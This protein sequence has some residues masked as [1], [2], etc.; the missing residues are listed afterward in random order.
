MTEFG[1]LT[2]LMAESLPLLGYREIY[3]QA[4]GFKSPQEI[5]GVQSNH[6]PGVVALSPRRRPII[7]DAFVP[8]NPQY[9]V[10]R[11]QLFW[12]AAV[13]MGGEFH[14][15]ARSTYKSKKATDIVAGLAKAA[16]IEVK[17]VWSV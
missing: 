8:G 16:G 11:W 1:Q 4:P 15:V 10:S 17:K 14:V 13:S 7:L 5:N 9:T 3:A 6:T 2:T 12:S